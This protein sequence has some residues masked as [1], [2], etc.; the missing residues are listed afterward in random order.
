MFQLNKLVLFFGGIFLGFVGGQT[1]DLPYKFF[2]KQIFLNEYG[3][4]VFLCD[5]AMRQH[6]IAKSRIV[7]SPS[8][9]TG[10]SLKNAEL[11]LIDCHEYDKFRKK[12]ITFGLNEN[13][14]SEMGLKAI[15]K[16][17]TDLSTLVKQHEI[18]Y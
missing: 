10:S 11:G 14:L 12:L 13:D 2:L 8:T 15:E 4:H 5:N 18:S 16:S 17:R 6:F 9:E 7:S 1:W 3:E